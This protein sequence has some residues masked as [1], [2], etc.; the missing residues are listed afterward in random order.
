ME[1]QDLIEEFRRQVSD[2]DQ[3]YLWSD[4]EVLD[5]A[6]DAQDTLVRRTGGLADVTVAAADIGSPQTRLQDLALVA[7]SPYSLIS[8]YV[9]RIRSGRLLTAARDI[10]VGQESDMQK[11]MVEDYGWSVGAAF[12][13][14]ETGDVR[15][16]VLGVRENYVRWVK[17]PAATDTCRLHVFRLP[18][19]RIAAQEDDLE[20]QA[21]HHRALLLHM[22]HLAYSKQ[23]AEARDDKQAAT[24]ETMFAQYCATAR[25]EID[26]VR[27]RPRVVQYGGL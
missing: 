22:K 26:R 8:P 15:H 12:D 20:V 14:A 18:Y 11:V 2:E 4:P 25:Q 10:I 23:D 3:P 27:Y 21:Q 13:D 16:G 1:L 17:V 7:S 9:L 5:Y 6:I 19:P 24:N